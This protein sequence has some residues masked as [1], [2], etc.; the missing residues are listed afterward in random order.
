MGSIKPS[1]LDE[2]RVPPSVVEVRDEDEGAKGGTVS[3]PSKSPFHV[4]VKI[5]AYL[6]RAAFKRVSEEQGVQASSEELSFS[7]EMDDLELPSKPSLISVKS[8][9]C[10]LLLLIRLVLRDQI[11][12]SYSWRAA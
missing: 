6:G 11:C 1:L 9:L 2:V 10:F 12:F 4:L 8:P 7:P 5:S 3:K